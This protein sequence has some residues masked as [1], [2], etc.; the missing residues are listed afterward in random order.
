[1]WT[2]GEHASIAEWKVRTELEADGVTH[3]V[4]HVTAVDKRGRSHELRADLLR[5]DPGNA[6]TRPNATIVNEGLAKWTYEG[7]AG[8]GISEYLHQLDANAKPVLAIE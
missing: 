5:V 8:Y 4:S 1:M 3:K 7:R 2:D 6:G